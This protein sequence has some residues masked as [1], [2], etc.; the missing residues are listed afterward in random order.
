MRHFKVVFAIAPWRHY[1]ILNCRF[2]ILILIYSATLNNSAFIM[3]KHL[4]LV[5]FL[6]VQI[7]LKYFVGLVLFTTLV[8]HLP[9]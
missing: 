2:H 3:I 8:A 1:L 5:Y 4:F 9:F 7:L 6:S